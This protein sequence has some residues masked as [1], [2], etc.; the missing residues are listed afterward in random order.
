M[1]EVI[2]VSLDAIETVVIHY[3]N[4]LS[5]DPSL[6]T[7]C[8]DDKLHPHYSAP[9]VVLWRRVAQHARDVREWRNGVQ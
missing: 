3:K 8:T 1:T 7:I 2:L 6:A 9:Q 4:G 5:N